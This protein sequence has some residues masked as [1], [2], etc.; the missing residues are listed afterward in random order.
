MRVVSSLSFRRRQS[1]DRTFLDSIV[2]DPVGRLAVLTLPAQWYTLF[3]AQ[4]VG[5]SCQGRSTTSRGRGA[6]CSTRS[7]VANFWSLP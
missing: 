5:I 4:G 7:I 1:A 3:G 6:D 2:V